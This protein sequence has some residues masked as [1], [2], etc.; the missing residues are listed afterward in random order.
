MSYRQ[1]KSKEKALI[2]L[3]HLKGKTVSE[4]C[5]EHGISQATFYKWRDQFLGECHNAFE[6]KTDR[7]TQRL[8]K[9]NQKLKSVIGELTLELK[10]LEL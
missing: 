10:K 6:P 4:I 8:H 9:E 1:W 2:I 5:N 7:H 3:S